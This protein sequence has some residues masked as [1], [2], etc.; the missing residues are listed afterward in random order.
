MPGPGGLGKA[1]FWV[2]GMG[3]P[4]SPGETDL[5]ILCTLASWAV[6]EWSDQGPGELFPARRGPPCPLLFPT[7]ASTPFHFPR[8]P[9]LPR[10]GE[11]GMFP[12][13]QGGKG[14]PV[15]R[16]QSWVV[17]WGESQRL[18]SRPRSQLVGG[19]RR[20]R[21][22]QWEPPPPSPA[23][24]HLAPGRSE[25]P[26]E[27]QTP[28]RL[29]IAAREGVRRNAGRWAKECGHRVRGGLAP[30]PGASGR[31]ASAQLSAPQVDPLVV[32]DALADAERRGAFLLCTP[33][34]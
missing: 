31:G 18:A 13:P 17:G 8:P 6:T 22:L 29:G 3:R 21:R 7:P 24:P 32:V 28:G 4:F 26:G 20:G 2:P 30:R 33:A 34:I 19:Q 5:P 27:P 15:L 10:A 25:G 9:S 14:I 12:R 23:P 1:G 11:L 16:R